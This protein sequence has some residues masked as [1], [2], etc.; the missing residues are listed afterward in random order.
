MAAKRGATSKLNHD[1]WDQE[2]E[3][4][5]QGTF[6]QASEDALK[7]RVIKK[8]RRKLAGKGVSELENG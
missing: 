6:Q 7:G 1:N 4:E 8:A 3:P 5:E 2:D